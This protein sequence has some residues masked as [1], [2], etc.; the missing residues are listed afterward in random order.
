MKMID[1]T[2]KNKPKPPIRKLLQ[3]KRNRE[4]ANAKDKDKNKNNNDDIQLVVDVNKENDKSDNES[5]YLPPSLRVPDNYSP[6]PSPTRPL[7]RSKLDLQGGESEDSSDTSDDDHDQGGESEDP[8]TE[9]IEVIVEEE[10]MNANDIEIETVA[11][12]VVSEKKV[13]VQTDE[14]D[15]DDYESHVLGGEGDGVH[16]IT[17]EHDIQQEQDTPVPGPAISSSTEDMKKGKS[18][19][20]SKDDDGEKCSVDAPDTHSS[21]IAL[22]QEEDEHV[23]IRSALES[24]V[25]D[26][27]PT[28]A[29]ADGHVPEKNGD[30]HGNVE[31]SKENIEP[32]SE[33]LQESSAAIPQSTSTS[34]SDTAND[35]DS[36]T[37][38]NHIPEPPPK[39]SILRASS[40]DR[41]ISNSANN[42][43][44]NNPPVRKAV[45]FADENGGIISEQQTID[46]SPSKLS[47][48]VRR[49]N[50]ALS[51]TYDEDDELVQ[52]GVVGRVLVLLMDPPTKQYELTSLPYPLVSNENEVVG[53]TQLNVL[54]RLVGKSAS[55]EP[56]RNKKY[57]ALMRPDDTEPMD[58]DMNILDY[59]IIKD[60]VLI[61]IPEGYDVDSC[62]KFSY[63][64]LQD[65]R[66]VKLLKKLK[67]HEKKAEKKRRLKGRGM[68][69]NRSGSSSSYEPNVKDN[70]D[71]TTRSRSRGIGIN[72]ENTPAMQT[73]ADIE[74]GFNWSAFLFG[75][76]VILILISLLAGSASVLQQKKLNES[77]Q[78]TSMQ[79]AEKMCGRG[80]FCK[81]FGV[82]SDASAENQDRAFMKKLKDGI[83]KWNLEGD[84]LML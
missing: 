34:T 18:T 32:E 80:M 47:R 48:R 77:L 16:G 2:T 83:R 55:F 65:R 25:A 43:N 76:A 40:V 78:N 1:T 15:A 24:V 19:D 51:A 35:S 5:N 28:D 60:E 17:P 39:R 10:G 4:N 29:S 57:T 38:R 26:L 11:V 70:A 20:N 45:S 23:E 13:H 21:V 73:Q 46:V 53:P 74:N 75:T 58:N 8:S 84:D 31:I 79:E 50:K 41:G 82:K 6:V 64:I 30:D 71:D 67:K 44:T 56:L 69:P 54:L 22:V 49:G 63:P 68:K 66:L 12:N 72:L 36:N 52:K 42:A 27:F 33:S 3:K 81:P 37:I 62:G 9:T 7:P 59:K 14:A 61:A